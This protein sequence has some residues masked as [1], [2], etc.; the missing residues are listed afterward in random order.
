MP[1]FPTALRSGVRALITRAAARPAD[2]GLSIGT[3][4]LAVLTATLVIAVSTVV[5]NATRLFQRDNLNNI[6][7][8]SDLLTSAKAGEVRAFLESALIRGQTIA[9]A[10]RTRGE[11][12][13]SET[14]ADLVA[15]TAITPSGRP[16]GAVWTHELL[17]QN[18]GVTPA[19]LNKLFATALDR[20]GGIPAK[21]PARATFASGLVAPNGEPLVALVS[22]NTQ[23]KSKKTEG[24]LA[25]MRQERLLGSFS[26]GGAYTLVL[27]DSHGNLVVHP[28]SNRVRSGDSLRDLPLVK[29]LRESQLD[30]SFQEFDYNKETFL[31]AYCRVGVGGLAVLSSVPEARA[32]EAGEVLVRRSVLIALMILSVAFAIAYLFAETIVAPLRLLSQATEEIAQGNFKIRVQ[33][34]SRDEIFRLSKS[35]NSMS[36]EIERKIQN[37]SKINDSAK[38]I[39]ATLEAEKLLTFSVDALQAL[40]GGAGAVAWLWKD[41]KAPAEPG[42]TFN[43]GGPSITKG[44]GLVRFAATA[45]TATRTEDGT[46]LLPLLLK[47]SA[48][49]ALALS[50]R[51]DGK[52]YTE[53]DL[54]MAG[55]I[56]TSVG[57]TLENIEL[58]KRTAQSARMEK[59]LE[60]AKLVQDT[61]FPPPEILLPGLELQ[62]FYT[63]AGECGGDW[64]GML[65]LKNGKVLLAVGDATGHGVPAAL[66]TATAKAV[67]SVVHRISEEVP[68]MAENPATVMH[69]LNKAVYESTR[70]AILMTFFVA[71]LDPKTGELTYSTASHDPIYWYKM[72]EGADPKGPGAKENIDVLMVEPG[73]RLGQGPE[74]QY[75]TA[76]VTMGAADRLVLYTDGLPEAKNP[77]ASDEYGER[78]FLRSIAKH[79][80]ASPKQMREGLLA[81]FRAFAQ[82]EPLHDDITL[83]I[84]Q[85]KA[86]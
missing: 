53:E 67:C 61:M 3:K 66:V 17:A 65:P 6:Y 55:T 15:V 28:D 80:H 76:T 58:L 68:Q 64:W 35:F 62:S 56:V 7:S 11:A 31:G 51:P 74:A 79:A 14:E 47:D 49:G 2:A 44:S 54:F 4:F 25:L 57:I 22:L 45:K 81:D 39:S 23:S 63:P 19:E 48:A 84:C 85:R 37:L 24:I 9:S 86:A 36:G 33:V 83:V 40:L 27:V 26:D 60:T 10:L 32:F 8:A 29:R 75:A 77:G 70:G 69:F 82:D 16:E 20:I 1:A 21:R 34:N 43:K 13:Q 42:V 52:A 73:P 30:R 38:V 72:P 5:G 78:K 18:L 41:P 12:P 46:L 71:V 59:E 50:A